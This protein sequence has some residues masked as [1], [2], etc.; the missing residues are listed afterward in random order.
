MF[1]PMILALAASCMVTFATAQD[2]P[3]DAAIEAV[4]ADQLQDF[5]NRDVAGAWE[6]ASPNIR[7][8]FRDPGNF[9]MMVEQGYPMVW[10][11]RNPQFLELFT[12]Q[13]RIWQRVRIEDANG[14]PHML[15]YQ[16]IQSENGWQINGVRLV[17][18]PDV[19][20]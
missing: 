1:K 7:M 13:G 4:I 15:D 16:M 17:P 2:T 10:S 3:P 11:N 14:V 12:D 9:G 18:L 5:N 20:A 6:H 8:M 19:G